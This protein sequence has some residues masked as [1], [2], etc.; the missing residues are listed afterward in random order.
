M[1]WALRAEQ[2]DGG[3]DRR[4]TILRIAAVVLVGKQSRPTALMS[5]DEKDW[6]FGAGAEVPATT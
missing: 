5:Q 2:V 4:P 3:E 1:M 6:I